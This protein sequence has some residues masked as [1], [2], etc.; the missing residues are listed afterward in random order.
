M[1][2][3]LEHGQVVV[4]EGDHVAHD[5]QGQAGGSRAMLRGGDPGRS[6][7]EQRRQQTLIERLER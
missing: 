5:V 6:P 7:V 3:A 2:D 1:H 4:R